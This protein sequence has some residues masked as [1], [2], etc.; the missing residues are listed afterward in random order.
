MCTYHETV[1]IAVLK[2]SPATHSWLR[3]VIGWIEGICQAGGQCDDGKLT[4]TL[5]ISSGDLTHVAEFRRSA[6]YSI[7][8]AGLSGAL[9][10][11]RWHALRWRLGCVAL[12]QV[13]GR[14]PLRPAAFGAESVSHI[15]DPPDNCDLN[16]QVLFSGTTGT[17]ML[18]AF[19]L[20]PMT[21]LNYPHTCTV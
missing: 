4:D 15:S 12:L 17:H 13:C 3:Y 18:T 14:G 1:K 2:V 5:L 10:T 8:Q 16:L 21:T 6:S 9:G 11:V 20:S 19:S 7:S